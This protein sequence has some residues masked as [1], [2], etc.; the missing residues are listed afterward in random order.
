MKHIGKSYDKVD[1][2]G[3][4][5]GKPSYTGDF[6]PK[7][8]LIIKV[9]RSPH[10]QAKIKSID[11]S[12]AKLIP[13]VEAIFTYE[14]VPNT[15]FTLAGQTYPEPSA[16]DALILDSVV[17]YVGDE[18]A[19]VVA[20]DEATALK[21]M[22]LIKVEYEVQKPVLDLCTAMDHETVVHPEDDI[23]NHIPVGQDYKRNICV[24]YHKRVGDIEAELAKCDYVVEGTYFDQ[25]T[26]Q[27]AM[28]PFQSFGYIDHLGR[29]VIVSSTQI[30]FHVRRH[31]ARALGIPASKIRVIKPRIG[32]GFGS[33]QTACTELM[34]AFVTWKLQ[35]PC[36]LLY[37]RTEAQTCSTTRHAREWYIRVGATK[38]GIIQVID[39]DSITDAG[40]HATHCFTTTTAGEHKS[41]P[42]YNKAKAVHYGTEG[43]YMNH[44]PGG[45]FRGYGAT[46]ALWPLECA[47]NRLADEMGID[48]AE[49]RQKNLIAAGERSL[50]YDPD[51]IMDSGLF[52]ETVN[53]VKEMARWDERPHSWDIDE[54]YRGGLGMALALQGSGV[55]NIDVASV[56]IRLGDDGNYTL[57]T[58]SSDMGMG[59]NTILTQMACE[60]LGCPMESMTVVES[61][62]DIVP[63]D[64]GSYASSTTYVTG[65]AAKMAAEEL[66]E[67][68]INKLA[69]FMDVKP[70]DIDFDGLVGTTKD[71]T[72]KM[73]V[74]E[75][76][77]KLLVGTTSEQL[78]GF[79]TWGSH[80]SPPPFMASIAEVKVDK[81]TGQIIPLHMYNCVDC[82]TVVNPK[83]ARVQ[84]EG[85]AVQA[86]GMALYEDVRY[87]SNGRLETNNFM[88]Y[89]IPTRQ[90]I[91]ELH[92]AFVESYEESGAYG[93]KSIGEIVINTACPAI[94]HAVKNAVGA[95]IRTLPMT[96]EKVFMGMDEKYKV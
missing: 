51:E 47:V 73:S 88:T 12:K 36:Y 27:S 92:T 25:A 11:T 78:T 83:L 38:D 20:K 68:I 77:P 13:G 23:L 29:I 65:T 64:P 31:I 16:Y 82:G 45:A 4:L 5:S 32:G 67:K 71:G 58:G 93:V 2:K 80:T 35:K 42:L 28:E 52:Q 55:A 56:E 37:D 7:D 76:A 72:K 40:A 57:Y 17:R 39:M 53:K 63:F 6:V 95:D 21:A 48:P 61:D 85:G 70:E 50:V 44:T 94:Q 43:V 34:T 22:P 3:I 69:Q 87:S 41:V 10:A 66:R 96:P 9:L 8:A 19:L 15:R 33:K 81:Q 26:R 18:V 46:E 60:A 24:S 91:G 86:I 74:Q 59:A 89:K 79:A 1:A 90:D 49:L 75:L 62:T 54:R 30:V 14:D 84:V